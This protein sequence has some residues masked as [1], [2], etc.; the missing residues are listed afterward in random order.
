MKRIFVFIL[1][2]GLIATVAFSQDP[3][4]KFNTKYYIPG[5]D[6]LPECGDIDNVFFE[7]FTDSFK[8][9]IPMFQFK[10]SG[11]NDAY[12]IEPGHGQKQLFISGEML[13]TFVI[14]TAGNLNNLQLANS[15]NLAVE[16]EL[17][18]LFAMLGKWKPAMKDNKPVAFQMYVPFKFSIEGTKFFI[19]NK[20]VQY[21]IGNKKKK[22]N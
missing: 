12:M 1:M 18:R 7:N 11:P 3:I 4:I 17:M 5:V 13:A 15:D 19:N 2:Y 14:D 22:K 8:V 16:Q 20:P 6:A 21:E 9:T 10:N